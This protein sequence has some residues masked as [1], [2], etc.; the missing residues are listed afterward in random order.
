MYELRYSS[1]TAALSPASLLES[2]QEMGERKGLNYLGISM[3]GCLAALPGL[4]W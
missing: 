1:E 4:L 2:D 3:L